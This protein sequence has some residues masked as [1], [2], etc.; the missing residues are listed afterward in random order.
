MANT[1]GMYNNKVDIWPMGCI[2]Y[3][4]VTG[5][6]PFDNDWAILQH[7][8]SSAQVLLPIELSQLPSNKHEDLA[9]MISAMLNS[10]ASLR[11]AA[12]DIRDAFYVKLQEGRMSVNHLASPP[13][14]HHTSPPVTAYTGSL[15][16]RG[17]LY[18]LLLSCLETANGFPKHVPSWQSS[19]IQV[20]LVIGSNNFI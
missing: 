14:N 15:W 19:V 7:Y 5:Q 12:R 16:E 18:D 4:I 6:L 2:L 13:A 20:K 1:K 9:N 3:Q 10:D 17:S 8:Q 11:P